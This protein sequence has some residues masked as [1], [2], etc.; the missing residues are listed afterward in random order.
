MVPAQQMGGVWLQRNY[1]LLWP[2]VR[3][4]V[5]RF[6]TQ[7]LTADG[8]TLSSVAGTFGAFCIFHWMRLIESRTVVLTQ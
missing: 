2:H 5:F 6:S 7:Q 1:C 4:Y 8:G 3:L